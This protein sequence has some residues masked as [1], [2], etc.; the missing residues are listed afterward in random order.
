MQIAHICKVQ[1]MPYHPETNNQ[2]E[3]FN[4]TLINMIG[5]LESDDK[6]HWRDYFPTLVH[7][8]TVPRTM[9]QILAP[10]ILCMDANLIFPLI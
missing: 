2:C 10:T 7:A 9:P 3:R 8:L 4:Q 6:Q 1:T 5:T